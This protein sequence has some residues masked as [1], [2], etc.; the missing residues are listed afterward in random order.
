MP[1]YFTYLGPASPLGHGRLDLVHRIVT[2]YIVDVIR[3]LQTQNYSSLC[4]KSH[5]PAAYQKS[6]LAWLDRTVWTSNCQSTFKNGTVDGKLVSL[7]PGSRLHMSKLLSTPRYED[8]D[9]TSLSPGLDMTFARLA[10]GF[11][12]E[13]DQVHAGGQADLT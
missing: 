8:F 13:E 12:I 10:N 3:K 6:A 7:H 4:P 9:W 1:N 11:T 2:N 5:I